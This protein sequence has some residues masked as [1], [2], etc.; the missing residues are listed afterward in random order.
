MLAEPGRRGLTPEVVASDIQRTTTRYFDALATLDDGEPNA[1]HVILARLARAG[2]LPVLITTN[3]D[4]FLERALQCEG[5]EF[6]VYRTEQEMAGFP[7]GPTAQQGVHVVKLHGCLSRPETITAT[8]EQEGRGLSPAKVAVLEALLPEF[9]FCF[10]GYS[11]ADLKVDLDYL[12][13]VSVVERARGFVWSLYQSVD[14]KETPNPNVLA[15][16]TR[17]AGRGMVVH[18]LLPGALETLVEPPLRKGYTAAEQRA[19][20][21]QKTQRLKASL[22][23]WAAKHVGEAEACCVIGSLLSLSGHP[24]GAVECFRQMAELGRQ[25]RDWT[26]LGAALNNLGTVF[27]GTGQYDMAMEHYREGLR[28]AEDARERIILLVNL[29]DVHGQRGEAG[30]ATAA[31]EEAERLAT[32]AGD[33]EAMAK[34]YTGLAQLHQ[35]TGQARRR[36]GVVSQGGGGVRVDRRKG[37]LGECLHN[38]GTVH[39]ILGE[40]IEAEV[41]RA[42]W[43]D[44][45]N[46][47]RQGGRGLCDECGRQDAA[48]RWRDGGGAGALRAGPTDSG[49]TGG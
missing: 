26:M 3:F 10:W 44:L 8:V 29:G 42:G 30:E 41:L 32:A 28:Y 12:R 19:W 40:L 20:T 22:D 5:V 36:G 48:P 46:A 7:H 43:R 13:M 9:T 2:L 47:R 4:R 1:N 33:R 27:K 16:R 37:L 39:R 34:V 38:R 23:A 45:A 31:Y 35:V 25:A 24:E 21:E 6:R 18:G 15:L 49:G 14:F 11:G 17:Y